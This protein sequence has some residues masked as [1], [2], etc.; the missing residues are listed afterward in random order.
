[1][2]SSYLA[3]QYTLTDTQYNYNNVPCALN[4]RMDGTGA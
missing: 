4:I 2:T 1:M 3:Q